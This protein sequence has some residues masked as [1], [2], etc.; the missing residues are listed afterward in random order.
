MTGTEYDVRW[1]WVTV[2]LSLLVLLGYATISFNWYFQSKLRNKA[3][4]AS[5][6]RLRTIFFVCAVWGYIFFT[7][8][9]NWLWW[10]AYDI[11]LAGLV[12]YTWTYVVR[13]RGLSLVG[14]RLAQ[15]AE[16]EKTA[17]RYREIAELLPQM[18]W[19]ANADGQIDFAN[20]RWRD[21]TTAHR[22]WLEAVHPDER[23]KV[24]QWWQR[25]VA[26]T[27][28]ESREVRLEGNA[29]YRTFLVSAT[30]VIHG[31]AI[32]WLGACADIEDQKLLAA[33]KEE[34]ARQKLFFLNALSHD[35][36][37]P[38]NNVALNAQMLSLHVTDSEA[39]Q[40]VKDIVE[41]SI[42][43]GRLVSRLLDFARVG[44]Q[45]ENDVRQVAVGELLSQVLR[46]FQP[47]AEQKGL[48]LTL[49]GDTDVQIST[50]RV[51]FERV[52]SNLLDNAIKYT[53]RGGIHLSARSEEGSFRVLIADTGIGIP[54]EAVPRL[55]DEF[56]QVNN[57]ERD[58][59]KGFGLGLAI[60]A[61]LARQLGG[62]VRLLSTAS[63]G[64]CFEVSI[65]AGLG[66][67]SVDCGGRSCG[68]ESAGGVHEAG[69]VLCS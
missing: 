5:L 60:C 14:E 59:S 41:N 38:L 44:V 57:H 32:K 3:S 4:S 11:A 50:D 68:Q 66:D 48:Y 49:D 24:A 67:A 31:R 52:I 62:D 30:P 21:Y 35:L 29:G 7:C 12:L 28:Q 34:Q 22:T 56:Y 55:F 19:T 58:K 61:S 63:E 13:M 53:Q 25:T 39:I 9:V 2:V 10:R 15:V 26:G 45:E 18:V 33:Q 20:K 69:G 42:A 37:A 46:R 40:G 43:A 47:T 27:K 65:S 1:A 6:A 8:N 16:L 51:K 54:A 17:E 64:S 23:R 36:R